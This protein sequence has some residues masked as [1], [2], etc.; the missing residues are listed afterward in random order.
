MYRKETCYAGKTIEVRKYHNYHV[1]PPGDTRGERTSET[2]EAHKKANDRRRRTDF[3]RKLNTAFGKG[4]LYLTLTYKENPPEKIRDLQKDGQEFCKTL[5]KYYKEK[6]QDLRYMWVMGAGV[7]TR[8][9]IHMVINNIGDM[10]FLE[11]LWEH[12]HVK[13]EY[14]YDDN[15]KDLA[16]YMMEN[17]EQ[18][19]EL[20]KQRGENIRRYYFTSHGLPKPVV[21][22]EDIPAATFRKTVYEKSIEKKG[23]YLE[24][25]SE[26]Y[27][28]DEMGY[29]YYGYTLIRIDDD[30]DIHRHGRA[31]PKG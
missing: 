17:A 25:E 6:E 14:I 10:S 12:G 28:I 4:D 16:A 2:S 3:R 7:R 26:Y 13:I 19:M 30:K 31:E 22:K 29:E 27:G 24:K 11:S 9:H 20:A 21:I 15:L 18:T 5:K 23:Y 1:P 8:R